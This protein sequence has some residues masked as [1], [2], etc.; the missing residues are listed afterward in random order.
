VLRRRRLSELLVDTGDGEEALL[1]GRA[2][3]DV[4]TGEASAMEGVERAEASLIGRPGRPH[5]RMRLLLGPQAAP[6]DALHRLTT[7]ALAVARDSARLPSLPAT[8]QLRAIKHRAQRV[9]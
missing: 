7:G 6:G 1:R 2:M 5:T 9:L 3:E 8:V 4:L